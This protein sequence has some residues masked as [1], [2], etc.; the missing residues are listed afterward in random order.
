MKDL[1]PLL[2]AAVEVAEA[3]LELRRAE[4]SYG[5]ARREWEATKSPKSEWLR[6]VRGR[7][8]GHANAHLQETLNEYERLRK[9]LDKPASL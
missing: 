9:D 5:D 7:R 3:V 2:V 8:A 6:K 4:K 1:P